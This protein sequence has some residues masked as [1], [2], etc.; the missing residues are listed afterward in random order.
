MRP[1]CV[2]PFPN[3]VETRVGAGATGSVVP[4]LQGQRGLS[5]SCEHYILDWPLRPREA[6]LPR[7]PSKSI[8]WPAPTQR[9][10][11]STQQYTMSFWNIQEHMHVFSGSLENLLVRGVFSS[12]SSRLLDRHNTHL[13]LTQ[14]N[15][16]RSRNSGS[17]FLTQPAAQIWFPA[18]VTLCSF[19]HFVCVWENG[20]RWF[21]FSFGSVQT[22]I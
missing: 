16:S 6:F 9:V 20:P 11:T 21:F 14:Q 13:L 3:P 18:R 12:T 2:T 17:F 1:I 19:F 22:P 5:M 8:K 10:S 4:E 7:A 15:T